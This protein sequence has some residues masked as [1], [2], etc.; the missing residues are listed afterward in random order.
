MQEGP[1]KM[2]GLRIVS[3]GR[4]KDFPFHRGAERYYRGKGYLR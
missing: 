2:S 3:E 1:L 4:P